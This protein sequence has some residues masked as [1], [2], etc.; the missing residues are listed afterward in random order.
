MPPLNPLRAFE[1]AGRL[2]S[3]RSAADELHVTPGAVSRQIQ[4]LEQYLGVPLFRRL[5]R[6]IKL[7]EEGERYLEEISIHLSGIVSATEQLTGRKGK[8]ILHI[9]AYMTFAMRWLIPR[10]PSFHDEHCQV[11][12]RLSASLEAVDFDKEHV[13]GAIRLGPPDWLGCEMDPLVEN[14]LIP[15]CSPEYLARRKNLNSL[16]LSADVLL[17]SLARPNDWQQ[18]MVSAGALAGQEN[19]QSYQSSVL[20]YEAAI[21][22]MGIAMAQRVLVA[23]DLASG[24]LVCPFSHSLDMGENT[25]YLVYPSNRLRNPE[26][27]LFRKW[28][29][30]KASDGSVHEAA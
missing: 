1:A 19:I 23:D 20:A 9:R 12:V 30:A 25:Y 14:H 27:R 4:N 2:K 28:I 6:S 8:K 29:K 10:L 18:W 26:F 5:P 17:H 13:D 15:V 11:E 3:I 7:T 16:D 22:G 21:R 24:Q